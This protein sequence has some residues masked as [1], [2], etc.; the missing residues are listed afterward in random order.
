MTLQ[1]NP[2]HVGYLKVKSRND[3]SKPITNGG[4]TKNDYF[5]ASKRYKVRD[6]YFTNN[7]YYSLKTIQTTAKKYWSKANSN[8]GT[9]MIATA[10]NYMTQSSNRFA[11]LW[12]KP[13]RK[14][15]LFG[16]EKGPKKN[17][18]LNTNNQVDS[19]TLSVNP[20][21]PNACNPQDPRPKTPHKTTT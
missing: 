12:D 5:K 4:R 10:Y 3:N 21:E 9:N 19:L 15:N 7:Y 14:K 8:Q 6:P 17:P 18:Y 13:D 2:S 1:M 11:P 20:Y 16:M